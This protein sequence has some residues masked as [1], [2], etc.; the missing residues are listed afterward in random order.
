MTRTGPIAFVMSACRSV[1]AGRSVFAR[2]RASCLAFAESPVVRAVFLG[3]FSSKP[4]VGRSRRPKPPLPAPRHR[5]V[6]IR[7]SRPL[8]PAHPPLY[9]YLPEWPGT[10]LPGSSFDP[11]RD[12]LC[13][14]TSLRRW[15]LR[16]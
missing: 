16:P 10:A 2:P 9:L 7:R 13:I 11:G 3:A 14:L 15:L 6:T 8:T 5:R 1:G 4:A 12:M